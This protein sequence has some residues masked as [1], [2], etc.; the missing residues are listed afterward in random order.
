MHVADDRSA[1]T[2]QKIYLYVKIP[3]NSAY[4]INLY[5]Y[6]YIYDI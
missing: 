1:N 3:I 2:V 4:F 5:C 6:I